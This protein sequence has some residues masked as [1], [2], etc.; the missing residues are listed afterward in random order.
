MRGTTYEQDPRYKDKEA[1]MLSSKQWPLEYEIEVKMQNV[2]REI[3]R[4]WISKQIQELLGVEDDI[5]AGLII[6]VLEEAQP[7]P[8][9][10]HIL[11]GEF[12]KENTQK[13]VIRLWR[14]LNNAQENSIGVPQQY[15]RERREE[16]IK[17][18]RELEKMI[19]WINS[20]AKKE[21]KRSRSPERKG[22]ND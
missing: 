15:I 7:C 6:S 11:I 1:K 16:L 19:D 13:F 21:K 10:I 14:F 5:L 22:R 17:K 18:K 20:I 12:L 4:T 2:N 3:V 9:K 8:K